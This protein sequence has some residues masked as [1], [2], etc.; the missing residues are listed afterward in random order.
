MIFEVYVICIFTI[1][2]DSVRNSDTM[3]HALLAK[4]N[5][6]QTTS[7]LEDRLHQM[8]KPL[9]QFMHRNQSFLSMVLV[10]VEGQTKQ[11]YKLI[12]STSKNVY[13]LIFQNET[14]S[15]LTFAPLV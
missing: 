8:K 9:I 7:F 13:F 10:S 14:K 5:A 6:L 11:Q 1:F 4:K 15:W 2:R 3:N 12:S